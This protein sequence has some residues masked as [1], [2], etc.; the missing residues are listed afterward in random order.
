MLKPEDNERITR[1]GPGTPMGELMRRYW[2]PVLLSG[3][4]PENDGVPLRVRIMGEDLIA[5][6]DSAG[7][8]GLVDAFCPHRRAPM[9][10]GRNEE[11]GLRC[12]YHGWKF[13]AAGTCVD[14]PSEPPDSLF[15]TKVAI[16]AYPTHE[17]GGM[18]WTYMGPPEEQPP[19][20]NYEWLRAPGT[21]RR[22]SKTFEHANWLQA[23]EGGMDTAHSSFAHNEKLGEMKGWIRNRDGA[24]R[25][26]VEKTDYGYTYVSTRKL[27]DDGN[28]IRV[29]HFVM[30]AQQM[31]GGITSWTGTGR[32]EMPRLDGHI[33]V[34]VD[35]EH[36][37]VYNMIW[38]YDK[39][40][41]ITEEWYWQDEARWGRGKD[42]LLPGYKLKANLS[43]DFFIDRQKQKTQTFTGIKGINTQDYALQEGM[44]AIVDR[45]KE[46]LGTS[47]KA[48]IVLRQ[49]LLEGTDVVARGE[50][51]RG[52]EP[53]TYEK[54][55]AYDAV[56]P[57]D[58]DWRVEFADELIAKW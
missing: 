30:P 12:V 41:P 19:F 26:D 34:P 58:K 7:K 27:G 18:V 55:R 38:A 21:H 50:Q 36:T 15:K 10:F 25:L 4:L 33:W 48:I 37:Y 2:Q 43:N 35:D 31:R 32:N 20:P 39:N 28:Y 44:G 6:R 56:I 54:V 29:Y 14:M 42:D 3:E 22:V 1:V 52:V 24:P 17:G 13:D 45:S 8:V 23:L 16:K 49:L 40:Y 51:P 9:F 5:F 53:S 11:C 46:H 57:Q 47:D